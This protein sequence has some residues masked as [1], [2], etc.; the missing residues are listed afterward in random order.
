MG[1]V[2]V[3]LLPAG[4]HLRTRGPRSPLIP[5]KV[6]AGVGSE[7]RIDAPNAKRLRNVGET[8]EDSDCLLA[9]SW[10][11]RYQRKTAE[12]VREP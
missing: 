8:R 7:E 10:Q 11:L 9:P 2:S 5:V 6:G 3:A 1:P 4:V 12:I